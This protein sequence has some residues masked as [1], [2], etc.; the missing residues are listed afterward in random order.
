MI[1]ERVPKSD[2]VSL[3]CLKFGLHDAV[4]HFNIEMKSSILVYEKLK[5]VPGAYTLKGCKT[6]NLKRIRWSLYKCN[7]Q[8]QLRRQSLR[9]K[10]MKA[11]NKINVT[12]TPSYIPG[13]FL[14]IF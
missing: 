2:Y 7:K 11:T 1:W 8:N 3:D 5:M 9:T 14:I 12:E 10:K 6:L 4:G 13:G